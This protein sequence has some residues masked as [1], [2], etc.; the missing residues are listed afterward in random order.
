MKKIHKLIGMLL[1][2]LM[3][4]GVF[5][6]LPFSVSAESEAAPDSVLEEIGADD[7]HE[8][9]PETVTKLSDAPVKS[10]IGAPA[11]TTD[12]PE[13]AEGEAIVFMEDDKSVEDIEDIVEIKDTIDIDGKD[14]EPDI[15]VVSDDDLTT[16]ELIDK[17]EKYPDVKY[18]IPNSVEKAS[19]ITNDTYSDYQWALSNTGQ[20]SGTPNVDLNPENAWTAAQSTGEECV[21][22]VIDSGIDIN[23]EDLKPVLWRNTTSVL[24]GYGCYGYDITGTN[25]DRQPRDDNGHG[26]HVAG[27][28][29]AAAN[30]NLG[31]SGVN[32]SGVKIMALRV[33][34]EEGNGYLSDIFDGIEY[35]IKAKQNGVNVVAVN[36]SIGG[37]GP[38]SKRDGYDELFN[39]LGA[40]GVVTCVA[41]GNEYENLDVAKYDDYGQRLYNSPGCCESPYCISVAALDENGNKTEF[42]NYGPKHVD[43]AAPG[44]NIL[45][46][47]S[48]NT[49]QPSIYTPTQIS[50]LCSGFQNFENGLSS[51]DFCDNVS[52]GNGDGKISCSSKGKLMLC[53]GYSF[54]TGQKSLVMTATE[55]S[56]AEHNYIIKIPYSLSTTS[57]NY[58]ISLKAK[59]LAGECDFYVFDGK[60]DFSFATS[61]YS[62]VGCDY[63]DHGWDN[64][65]FTPGDFKSYSSSK[66]RCI[67]IWITSKSKQLDVLIDDVAVSKQGL[68]ASQL[69]KYEFYPGTSMAS[70]FVAG[71]FALVHN[72]YPSLNVNQLISAVKNSAKTSSALSG[73][74][75]GS[76]YLDLQ[77]IE[78]YA[79]SS[80]PA[81]GISL[82][83]STAKVAVGNT[84]TLTATVSPSTATNK[85]VKW[86]SEDS[87]I[88]SVSN[89]VVT[90]KKTGVVKIYAE[91]HN[92]KNTYCTVTVTP[93]ISDQPLVN[94]GTLKEY[95]SSYYDF[96]DSDGMNLRY[97]AFDSRLFFCLDDDGSMSFHFYYDIDDTWSAIV[98]IP[99]FDFSK[100][101]DISP[102]VKM[103]KDDTRVFLTCYDADARTFDHEQDAVYGD[104]ES[105]DFTDSQVI[106]LTRALTGVAFDK[107]GTALYDML[108]FMLGDIGFGNYPDA[109][110]FVEV[111]GVS[112]NKSSV[113]LNPGGSYTLTATI[114]PSDATNKTVVWTSGNEN[115]AT[116]SGGKITAKS[117]G[118]T[119]ITATAHNGLT[120][121]CKVTVASIAVT[122]V[123]LSKSSLALTP[124][125]SYTLTA[126]VSPSNATNKSVT[127]ST[128]NSSV[129]T[130][131]GGKVTAKGAGT[132]TI[133]AKSNNGKTATC[134]VTV[135][136]PAKSIKLNLSSVTMTAGTQYKIYATITPSN[137]TSKVVY[138]SSSNPSVAGM[139][140]GGIIKAKKAGTATITAST[141]NG[142][143]TTCK[144]TVKECAPTSIK[145]NL[146]SV[147]MTAGTKYKL[148]AT[149]TPSNASNKTVYWSSS[150]PSVAGMGTGGVIN[151]KKAG[152][153]TITA[154][155]S[156]GKKT[157]CKVTVK[158]KK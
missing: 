87:T 38:L 17:L 153:C 26:S 62:F 80:I 131:S 22:A 31:I 58:T 112:L 142:K 34:D 11:D 149:I 37:D 115:V 69:G 141:N 123:S 8:Q 74:V 110:S 118:S 133:T 95:I 151:A 93:P 61:G 124:G 16:K 59:A 41:S 136:V 128:S 66:N 52:M 135:S 106:T 72:A 49:F 7:L 76:R 25:S 96:T 103:F 35:V 107:F 1:S 27:I 104:N 127:W 108:G 15:A 55:T 101:Y 79:S 29:A 46:T 147:T 39:R 82:N 158:A 138:W 134:K 20:N 50:N 120:A 71:A 88:A 129:A 83:R 81:T 70:P 113:T 5:T 44:A 139:A 111:T 122:G 54:G 42:S 86:S 114:S 3:V 33:L 75:E 77:S 105:S 32:K 146:S 65:S 51:G 9:I 78:D 21:V 23:H 47:V 24:P 154:K 68:S 145:L 97:D 140:S 92:G 156:N 64:Y 155:T 6:A 150:N 137:A 85:S 40:L 36:I 91:T 130:V 48:N 28:I 12:G 90:G 143:S 45:S 98:V 57:T 56:E 152:S 60:S 102:T 73:Y 19:G 94:I 30:N 117:P 99:S 126:T 89:G 13:Y 43:I 67:I 109:A 10:N 63:L 4:T 14:S 157:T 121:T 144:V 18:A 148:Y 53:T 116:V 100:S 2:A 84:V 132:A 125:D 119:T